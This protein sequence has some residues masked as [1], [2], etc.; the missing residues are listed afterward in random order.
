MRQWRNP[1]KRRMKKILH[2]SSDFTFPLLLSE[3]TGF[4]GIEL[5]HDIHSAGTRAFVPVC[6]SGFGRASA[7]SLMF[8]G[9][10]FLSWTRTCYDAVWNRSRAKNC[11][12][13]SFFSSKLDTVG[14]LYSRSSLLSGRPTLYDVSVVLCCSGSRIVLVP[15]KKRRK[16]KAKAKKQQRRT[17]T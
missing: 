2:T 14:Y 16:A 5:S 4:M 10:F 9:H 7:R 15:L 1:T 17:V 11:R 6:L 12:Y 8:H 3:R 13:Y